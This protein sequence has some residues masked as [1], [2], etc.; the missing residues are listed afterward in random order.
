[1][2]SEYGN[3]VS[4]VHLVCAVCVARMEMKQQVC[5]HE[6]AGVYYVCTACVLGVYCVCTRC[7]LRA[8]QLPDLGSEG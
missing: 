3:E 8:T 5:T 2:G 6:V 7:A 4:G 1:M